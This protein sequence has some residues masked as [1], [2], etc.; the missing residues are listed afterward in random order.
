MK[1][2]LPTAGRKLIALIFALT[3]VLTIIRAQTHQVSVTDFAFSPSSLVIE[4]GDTVVWTNS[5]GMH[6]VNGTQGTYAENPASFGNDVG[7]GWTYTFVFTEPGTY[8]YRCD[9]HVEFGMV[10]QIIVGEGGGGETSADITLDFTSMNPHLGQ[11]LYLALI[12]QGSGEI[13]QKV[14]D[15]VT[16]ADFSVLFAEVE[17]GKS[18]NIDFYADHNL[19]GNYNAPPE[20]HAWRLEVANL[21]K[22]TTLSF[23]HNTTFTDI[24]WQHSLTLQF[25]AMNP[26]VG[27][28]L[29]VYIIDNADDSYVD[30]ITVQQIAVADFDVETY[31]VNVDGSYRIDFFADLSGNGTYDAPPT[32]HAWRIEI[33]TLNGD[34]VIPFVHNTDFTNIFETPTGINNDREAS[35]IL[36]YP[37]PAG[38]F[39][40]LSGKDIPAG[41][42]EVRILSI[43]GQVVKSLKWTNS[44]GNF[45]IGL[46]DL[47]KGTYYLLIQSKDYR[48]HAKLVKSF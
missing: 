12:E 25:S 17:T 16:E 9:P 13:L 36:L 18:Y 45:L 14:H 31:N 42:L 29:V 4:V 40:T 2:I 47:S 1:A 28:M 38:N 30:T 44:S 22:D 20:D 3:A 23:V 5:Q 11:D 37:N 32:D 33:E 24:E 8:D 35:K 6:N 27:Q 15:T 19:S 41:E 46:N 48:A 10:G 7:E 43:S 34:T 26:H 21:S 39:V